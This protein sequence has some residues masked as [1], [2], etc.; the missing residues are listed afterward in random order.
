MIR[1][2]ADVSKHVTCALMPAAYELAVN[3]VAPEEN[4]IWTHRFWIALVYSPLFVDER[5]A[6]QVLPTTARRRMTAWKRSSRISQA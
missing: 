2:L 3:S 5:I 4:Q 1:P 6:N